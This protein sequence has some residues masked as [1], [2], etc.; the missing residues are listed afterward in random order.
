MVNYIWITT[1]RAFLHHYPDAPEKV[2]YLRNEHR[3]VFHFK[4]YLQ[5]FHQDRDVEF[6]MFKQ[7]VEEFLD[8]ID[9]HIKY[10]SCEML[11]QSLYE[12]ISVKYPKRKMMFEISEDGENG[13]LMSFD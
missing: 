10:K 6:I 12:K 4:V 7:E 9:N 2:A 13:V 8:E 11:A 3:H 5:V 1:R